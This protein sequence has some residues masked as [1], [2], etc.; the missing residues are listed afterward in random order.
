MPNHLVTLHSTKSLRH[1]TDHV[2]HDA[3]GPH[4]SAQCMWT[5]VGKLRRFVI[6]LGFSASNCTHGLHHLFGQ[7]SCAIETDCHSRPT[8]LQTEPTQ[9]TSQ[10]N[11][12]NQPLQPYTSPTSQLSDAPAVHQPASQSNPAPANR[13]MCPASSCFQIPGKP[14]VHVLQLRVDPLVLVRALLERAL[15]CIMLG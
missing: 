11:Q 8:S 14:W 15:S 6:G 2:Q 13:Q 3:V 12:P 1:A 4:A 7:P 5:C 10:P 9:P